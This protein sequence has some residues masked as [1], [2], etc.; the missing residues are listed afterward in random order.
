MTAVL[1][2]IDD[3]RFYEVEPPEGYYRDETCGA[4]RSLPWPS[5]LDDLPPTL[6]FDVIVWGE[7]WLVHH[8]T[9]Q[10]WRYTPK[11][12]RFL[13]MF[14]A[15]SPAQRWVYRRA[16]MR[17]SKGNGKS[18]FAAAMLL[19]EMMG[20]VLFD[21]FDERGNPI[22]R[23]HRVA[24]V[25]IAANSEGQAQDVL[26][27]ANAMVSKRLKLQMGFE[28][29]KI[30]S[31][32]KSG[33][34]MQILTTSVKSAEGDPATFIALEEP[35]HMTESSGGKKMADVV[36][37]NVAK[38]PDG[39][40]RI[41]EYT[42]AHEE[43]GASVAEDTYEAW[44]AQVAGRTLRQDI[45]YDSCEAPAYLS[46]HTVEDV[47]H[48]LKAAYDDAPWVDLERIAA[49]IDDTSTS[50][51]DSIRF[52]F[53]ATA[54]NESAWVD[55]RAVDACTSS[56]MLLPGDRVALA[57]D[58][59]KSIDATALV[60]CRIEDGFIQTIAMWQRP[61]GDRGKGW[62]VPRNEVK[63][64][65]HN[66]RTLYSVAAFF[67]DPSPARDDEDESPYWGECLEQWHADFAD[68][69][70]I[71]A[72]P[73]AAVVFDMRM[74]VPGGA[75]R[76]RQFTEE[77]M[78]TVQAIDEDQSFRHDGAPDLKLHMKHARRRPNPWGYSLGKATRDSKDKVDLAVAMVI[79]R[80]ARRLVLLSGK[81][82][83]EAPVDRTAYME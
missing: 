53:N 61:H 82:A 31:T 5:T 49:E 54:A 77:A 64:A 47:T 57:L 72:S 55:P 70:L 17:R 9:G 75:D 25:Q 34:R 38:S 42:N 33:S 59:S 63:A 58:C 8:L 22:G 52:Y 83:D 40:A 13:V 39:Q 19:T 78:L 74:S 21:H 48:G 79:A 4:W 43:G 68:S 1:D 36:R 7:Q 27:V 2:K 23:N 6:G 10:P 62:L 11:Q 35:H 45:L 71:K 28:A 3:P 60:A 76:N 67:V 44:Q 73:R 41:C 80:L 20:P 18:P 66:V 24:L 12:K 15:L 37:R 29:G 14:Y 16:V 56:D 51:A 65:V 32:T 30:G 26:L 46:L 50:E 69:L 81:A